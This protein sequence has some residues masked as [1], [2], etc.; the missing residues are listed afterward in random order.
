[1]GGSMGAGDLEKLTDKLWEK[2]RGKEGIAVICGSNKKIFR[3]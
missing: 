1:M 2:V 3:N